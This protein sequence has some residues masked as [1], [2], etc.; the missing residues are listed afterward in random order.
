M[1]IS[2]AI[3]T[4]HAGSEYSPQ[5]CTLRG[6]STQTGLVSVEQHMGEK[7]SQQLCS[8][9]HRIRAAFIHTILF[10]IYAVLTSCWPSIFPP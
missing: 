7:G 5:T 9:A 3:Q 8:S 1:E 2:S 6:V 10:C 4:I